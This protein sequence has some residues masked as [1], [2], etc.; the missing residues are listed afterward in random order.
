ASRYS[1]WE[2]RV[3][4]TISAAQLAQIMSA[5]AALKF[6]LGSLA[7]V[8]LVVGGVGIMNVLL[9]SIAERTREIGVRKALGARRPDV[10]L[11]FLAEAVAMAAMGSGVGIIGG[12]TLA[13]TLAG[14][15]G[16]V[17]PGLPWQTVITPGTLVIGVAS[18][19]SVGLAFGTLP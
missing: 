5:M 16:Y 12:C 9:A 7:G 14:L 18:A 3:T 10:L 11:Q 17:L 15:M 13:F 8:S 1:H 19:T 4:I 2:S 6:V